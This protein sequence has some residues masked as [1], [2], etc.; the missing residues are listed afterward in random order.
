MPVAIHKVGVDVVRGGVPVS[1]GQRD[2]GVVIAQHVR[3]AIL[4][5]VGSGPVVTNNH[6][7]SQQDD[8]TTETMLS[9]LMTTM[10]MATMNIKTFN[11]TM[12]A[13]T[14]DHDNDNATVCTSWDNDDAN[15]ITTRCSLFFFF[16]Y[17][18]VLAGQTA[19]LA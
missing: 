18:M 8:N 5:E 19:S 10:L 16:S 15:D 12:T 13:A 9:F 1:Q 2:A 6:H 7:T 14:N 17:S 11:K 3:V 4:G